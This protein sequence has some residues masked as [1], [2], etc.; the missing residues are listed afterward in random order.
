MKTVKRRSQKQEKSVAKQFNA[1]VTVASG[2]LWGMKADVR[3]DKFLIECKTTEKEY[4]TVTAKV[5]EKIEE[6]ATRDH[7]RIPILI[8]DVE[9][10]D[11]LVVFN[12]KHFNTTIPEPYDCTYNGD[13]QKSFR[14]GLYE[15]IDAGNEYG[16]YIYAKLFVICGK[17]KNMLCYMRYRDFEETFM[18]NRITKLSEDER[19]IAFDVREKEE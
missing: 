17:K 2:A 8:V 16:E 18:V 12:P 1:M 6:E 7:M 15:L 9:D 19:T 14:V 10:R 11:R 13:N 4:Y 3:N 5:W